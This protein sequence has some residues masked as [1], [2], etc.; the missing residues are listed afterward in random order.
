MRLSWVNLFYKS[1]PPWGTSHPT[2]AR[3]TDLKVW[4][5][6]TLCD[7]LEQSLLDLDELRGFD[8]V[9]DLLYLAQEHHLKFAK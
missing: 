9:E 1:V 6:D 3:L 5:G 7:L 8:H 4:T 2:L